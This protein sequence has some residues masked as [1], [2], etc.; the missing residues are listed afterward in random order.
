M[1]HQERARKNWVQTPW[2]VCF[3]W[4][5]NN[6]GD[7]QTWNMMVNLI[8]RQIM[9]TLLSVATVTFRPLPARPFFWKHFPPTSRNLEWNT[10][11]EKTS[12]R[13]ACATWFAT[14]ETSPPSLGSPRH[15]WHQ[16]P[17]Q[18]CS[19]CASSC[20][21]L[22]DAVQFWTSELSPP[23]PGLLQ[24]KTDPSLRIAAKANEL[25]WTCWTLLSW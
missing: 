20:M 14:V 13:Y 3:T 12:Y 24:V 10:T 19:K 7:T 1:A 6:L 22:L 23:R 21:N 25:A 5:C 18:D 15:K 8:F 16:P 4:V 17:R 2:T 9:T 11:C